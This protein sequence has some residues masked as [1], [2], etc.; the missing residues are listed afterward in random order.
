MSSITR[1]SSY[2]FFFQFITLLFLFDT[3]TFSQQGSFLFTTRVFLFQHDTKKY[4][5]S[6]LIQ[7]LFLLFLGSAYYFFELVHDCFWRQ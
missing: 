7:L 6:R 2:F 1:T 5:M 3:V 4:S